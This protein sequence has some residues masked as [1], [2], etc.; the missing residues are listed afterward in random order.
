MDI[1]S[2]SI[3][4]SCCSFL[5]PIHPFL[6]QTIL[7]W[8]FLCLHAD[9]MLDFNIH[10]LSFQKSFEFYIYSELLTDLMYSLQI[11]CPNVTAYIEPF[12]QDEMLSFLKE[13]KFFCWRLV[14]TLLSILEL[15]L[16]LAFKTFFWI[17]G[18][19]CDVFIL[20]IISQ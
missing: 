3:S 11:L 20:L 7:L 8:T 19:I 4:F 17:F 18:Y 5:S 1:G 13:N 14:S 15:R 16:P 12:F 10:S 2:G 6:I 9:P